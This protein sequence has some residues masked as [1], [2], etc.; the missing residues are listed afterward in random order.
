ML[1]LFV[2]WIYAARRFYTVWST[3]LNFSA[4][5][6]DRDNGAKGED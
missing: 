5:G 1:L 6:G 4:I 3:V 2:V